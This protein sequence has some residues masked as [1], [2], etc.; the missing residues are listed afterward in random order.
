MQNKA[1]ITNKQRNITSFFTNKL[2][3]AIFQ[4]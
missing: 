1:K 4:G 3:I 2:S